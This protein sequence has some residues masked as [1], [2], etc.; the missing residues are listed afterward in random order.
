MSDRMRLIPF[1]QLIQWIMTEY[2]NSHSIFGVHQEHFYRKSDQKSLKIFGETLE[3]PLGPAAGPHTQL[4]QNIIAAYLTGSRFFELKTVQTLDGEDLPVSKPCI[5]A[6]DEGYNVEWSTELTVPD[7][8]NEYVKAWFV[9]HIL[10]REL[11]LGSDKGFIFNMSVGYDLEGIQ[12]PKIDTFIEGLKDASETS[13][14]KEC[15]EYILSHT[16]LFKNIDRNFVEGISPYICSSIT[17]STLHGCPPEEI[18]RI[19]KYLL[20]EKKLNTYVKCN[21]T[22]LGYEFAKNILNQMGYDYMTFDDHHFRNDLQFEEAVP[23][24]ARLKSF[25]QDLNLSFG[26]KLSNTFPVKI[27]NRELPGEEMYMSG[28]A[29]YPLTINLAGKLASAFNGDLRIS[30]SGGADFLNIDKIYETGIWPITFATTLLKPGGYARAKQMAE[31]LDK[32]AGIPPT[33]VDVDKLKLLADSAISDSNHLKEKREVENR[34]IGKNVPLTDC[35]MAP[36]TEGCPIGQDVPEYIRLTGEGK[37]LEAL[38]VITRKNPLPFITGTLCNHRC[39]TKCT[40]LDYDEPVAIRQTKLIAAEK[41]YQALIAKI[42]TPEPV[43][44]FKVAVIGGGPTGLAAAYFL[45]RNGVKVTV[46]DRKEKVGG[47]IEHIAP[48]FRIAKEAIAHDVELI[49][50]AGVQFELGVDGKF[51]IAELRKAGFKYILIAIGAWKPGLLKLEACDKEML[52][53]LEFLESYNQN[54]AR[55]NLGKNVAVIGAGNSAMDAARAA[56]R[57]AGVE[58]V[59]IVYRRTR[60]YMPADREELQLALEEGVEFKEL[61]APVAY[62]QGIL[63]CQQMELGAPDHSGRRTPVAVAGT[64]INLPVDT[65]IAAVGENVE[66]GLFTDNGIAIDPGGTVKVDPESHETNIGGVFV[67]G[68]ALRG[69]A[70]IVEGIADGTKFAGIVIAREYGKTLNLEPSVHFDPEKQA[71]DIN[72]KKGVIKNTC[73][74]GQDHERCL[75][76]RDICNICVEVCPNRANVEIAGNTENLRCRNQVIHLDGMCNE[77]GNCEA[78]CPYDSAPYKDKFTLYWNP[79]D[80][81]DNQNAGCLR[82]DESSHRFKVRLGD[83]LNEITF[84]DSGNCTDGNVSKEIAE[85]IWVTFKNYRYLF[86]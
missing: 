62:Q 9:L 70:T 31:L 64:Y 42:E 84:D 30:Y 54:Q 27:I 57:V 18:E 46:F 86:G 21:P 82:V 68:D 20:Q 38:E 3:N 55:L 5:L 28:R 50:K 24:I 19:A 11:K 44:D 58:N 59:Y 4:A 79:A 52:N 83:K 69:P 26:V 85:L 75:E 73:Q 61:I 33:T 80:F 10:A 65:V 7:A 41:G 51:S 8:F 12:S 36:C 43:S 56:K 45:G 15:K 34:K 6:K 40:R 53:V 74:A 13:I 16:G 17:L 35:F 39:M 47:I 66:T 25:A 23:M 14:W 49:Q 37:Y 78:F 77:C 71:A 67:G 60:K 1:D 29:L 72:R 48:K 63:K 76:C 2:Q 81:E 22:L 32:S